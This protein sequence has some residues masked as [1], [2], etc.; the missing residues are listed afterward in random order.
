MMG[1]IH[2]EQGQKG[3]STW[4]FESYKHALEAQNFEFADVGESLGAMYAT[5]T[6]AHEGQQAE[7]AKAEGDLKAAQAERKKEEE[8]AKK[9]GKKGKGKEAEQE[10]KVLTPGSPV[11]AAKTP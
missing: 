5:A 9:K 8:K 11:K 7:L 10:E 2:L 6:G 3:T 4:V 1:A